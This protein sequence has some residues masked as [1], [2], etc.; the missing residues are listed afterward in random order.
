MFD[1][2]NGYF[3]LQAL[4]GAVGA[5]VRGSFGELVGRLGWE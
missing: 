5:D 2:E 4:E 3:E 1:M